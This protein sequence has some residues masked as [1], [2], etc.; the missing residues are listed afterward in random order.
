MGAPGRIVRQAT[1]RDLELIA[2]AAAGY[3]ERSVGYARELRP[4]Q[5]A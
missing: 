1:D 5:P 2:R 4:L 3:R